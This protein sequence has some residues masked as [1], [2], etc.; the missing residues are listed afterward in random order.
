VTA[1]LERARLLAL[2]LVSL[3]A[4]AS[5]DLAW[6]PPSLLRLVGLAAGLGLALS[7]GT[8]LADALSAVGSAGVR[9]RARLLALVLV[10]LPSLLAVAVAWTAPSLA[11][12]AASA[13]VLVQAALLLVG[14]SLGLTLLALWG[15]L[16]L[17][18]VAAARGGLPGAVAFASLLVLAG[19]CFALDHAISRL[20]IRP[21]VPG[22]TPV[23]VVADALRL[24]A[25]PALLLVLSLWLAPSWSPA[26]S[27]GAGVR[28][29][30]A[31]EVRRAYQWL[32]LA[33]LAGMGALTLV[34]RW[35]RGREGEAPPLAELAE[36]QVVA[37]ELLDPPSL[38]DARY[39]APR[40][41]VI[42]AYL[43]FLARAREAGLRLDRCLTPREI[44]RRVVRPE[45]PLDQLTALFMDARYGPVEPSPD[46]VRLADAA[47]SAVCATLRRRRRGRDHSPLAYRGESG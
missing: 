7:L 33:A 28:L 14:E 13:L 6:Q 43:R 31:P 25:V 44:E 9:L 24:L 35:L 11:P 20:A 38:D 15:A 26:T 39:S 1:A 17:S 18:L 23:R 45:Q 29:P 4:A 32:V 34:L 47:S 3:V 37:E 42:R 16:F 21:G 40:G 2:Y 19:V 41:R 8:L 46:A 12:L 10:P 27:A 30:E 22:P 36:T 5:A